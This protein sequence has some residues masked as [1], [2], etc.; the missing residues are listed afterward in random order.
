MYVLFLYVTAQLCWSS[1]F[2]GMYLVHTYTNTQANSIV[3]HE[4]GYSRD[5]INEK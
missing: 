2:P 5:I 3:Y 4:V 1:V